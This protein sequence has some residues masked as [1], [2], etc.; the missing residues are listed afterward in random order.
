MEKTTETKT[1]NQPNKHEQNDTERIKQI[2]K[3]DDRRIKHIE[4]QY[5]G[6]TRVR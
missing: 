6:I 1:E 5:P 4:Q 2:V 3:Q